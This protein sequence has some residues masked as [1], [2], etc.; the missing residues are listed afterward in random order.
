MSVFAFRHNLV[1][2][3]QHAQRIA[4]HC[5][6]EPVMAFH[7]IFY[8][9][10][11]F[12]NRTCDFAHTRLPLRL[13]PFLNRRHRA[14]PL[15]LGRV[16]FQQQKQVEL[17]FARAARDHDAFKHAVIAATPKTRHAEAAEGPPNRAIDQPETEAIQVHAKTALLLI[18]NH[19]GF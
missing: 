14:C 8:R 12:R 5:E 9:G 1:A 4:C 17:L 19:I 7:A 18:C 16:L 6:L 15:L 3:R 13:W 11:P 10:Q 2:P